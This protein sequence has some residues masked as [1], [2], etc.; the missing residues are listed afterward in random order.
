MVFSR[1]LVDVV[2][3]NDT[4][5]FAVQ[6]HLGLCHRGRPD[7]WMHPENDHGKHLYMGMDVMF[8]FNFL[9]DVPRTQVQKERK[10]EEQ[11]VGVG[12]REA[13]AEAALCQNFIAPRAH[14]KRLIF[15]G[16]GEQ[17]WNVLGFIAYTALYSKQ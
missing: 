5:M 10:L 6:Q 4:G 7:V 9:D 16:G 2:R 14:D 13:A 15:I 11:D 12:E 1:Y 8:T 3:L 17:I